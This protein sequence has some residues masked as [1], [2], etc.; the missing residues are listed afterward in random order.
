MIS[1]LDFDLEPAAVGKPRLR[2]RWAAGKEG[3]SSDSAMGVS[4][5]VVDLNK[6]L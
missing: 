6:S 1:L 3:A 2:R 4:E 5:F